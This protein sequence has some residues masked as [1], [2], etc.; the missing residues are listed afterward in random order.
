MYSLYYNPAVAVEQLTPVLTLQ[1]CLLQANAG[2]LSY[3]TNLVR[4]NW[5]VDDL[6]HNPIQKP[7]LV[8]SN[9]TIITGDTRYMALQL[10]RHISHVPVLMTSR[11]ASDNWIDIQSREELG[12]LLNINPENILTNWDWKERTLDWIEF[13]YPCT[14]DHMHDES[15]RER[16]IRNYLKTH[17]GTVFNQDWLLEIVDWSLYDH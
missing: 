11:Y 6:R 12:E 10:H 8:D 14:V 16:M 15:Q 5:M 3:R 17:P 13:A 9:L 1:E 4:L 2:N 7:F